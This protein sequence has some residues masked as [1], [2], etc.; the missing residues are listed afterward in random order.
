MAERPM[1]KLKL[2]NFPIRRFANTKPNA[3]RPMINVSGM[4]IPKPVSANK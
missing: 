2:S 1:T 4:M 3:T